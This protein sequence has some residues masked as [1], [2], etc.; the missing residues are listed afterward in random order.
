MNEAGVLANGRRDPDNEGG[1]RGLT[2]EGREWSD[3]DVVAVEDRVGG[4]TWAS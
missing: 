2:G 1:V 4:A 3:D